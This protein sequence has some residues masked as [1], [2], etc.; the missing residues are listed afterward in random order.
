MY[1]H[2]YSYD[3]EILTKDGWKLFKDVSVGELVITRDDN[4]NGV[5]QP[6]QK[7]FQYDDYKRLIEF[8]KGSSNIC[9][10]DE[11]GILVRYEEG[12]KY[13]K[14]QAI[15]MM[16]KSFQSPN[17]CN[18]TNLDLNIG[19]DE[20]RLLAWIITEGNIEHIGKSRLVRI[21]QSDKP[22]VSH[23]HIIEICNKLGLKN[24][25]KLIYKAGSTIHGQHRNYDAYRI[26]IN[27][28]KKLDTLL[29]LIPDKKLQPWMINLS[30]RQFNIFF[31]ELILG[32]GSHT[33]KR[34]YQYATKNS[35]EADIFQAMCCLNGYRASILKRKER[36]GYS[37]YSIAVNTKDF[38]NINGKNAKFV[39]N[40]KPVYCVQV[41]N[42]NVL[43]RRGGKALFCGNTH[44]F[45]VAT[46]VGINGEPVM[47]ASIGTL[48]KKDLSYLVGKPPVNWLNMFMYIDM[49]DDGTFSP[50]FVPIVN[51]KFYELGRVFDGSAM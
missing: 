44:Q 12:G 22:K 15:E 48:S 39:D 8:K 11:H 16:G 33:S 40:D 45:Q 21:A 46:A 49:Y 1:G 27:R 47:A 19:D 7:K 30:S 24:S 20:L 26:Y 5:W 18:N 3:T 29:D 38:V 42:G 41:E 2:C 32:D 6:V 35:D 43:V 23:K 50:H 37:M 34:N 14:K 25:F 13:I 51:G 10:T 31:N 4:G 17:S 28:C 36:F 9:V